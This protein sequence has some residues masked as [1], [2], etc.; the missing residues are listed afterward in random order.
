MIIPSSLFTGLLLP[1]TVCCIV[2]ASSFFPGSKWVRGSRVDRVFSLAE[3]SSFSLKGH[4]TCV[5][6][7]E[8]LVEVELH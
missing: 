5:R 7:F 4:M 3:C 1:H 6:A 2:F 8:R